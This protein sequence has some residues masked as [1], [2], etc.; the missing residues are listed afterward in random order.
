M[1]IHF[2]FCKDNVNIEIYVFSKNY[3]MGNISY[4]FAE[5]G[6]QKKVIIML[7]VKF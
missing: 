1:Q 3:L 6:K 4:S 5:R 7:I 2:Q